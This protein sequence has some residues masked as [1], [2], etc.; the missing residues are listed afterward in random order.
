MLKPALL[1]ENKLIKIIIIT[2]G[3]TNHSYFSSRVASHFNVKHIY[4]VYSDMTDYEYFS[5]QF[6]N[7]KECDKKN[8]IEEISLR[9]KYHEEFLLPEGDE[10]PKVPIT[11]FKKREMINKPE[12]I[13]EIISYK[14]T[15]VLLYGAPILGK[16]ILE[17]IKCPIIN[18]HMGIST[19]YRGGMANY[20]ALFFNDYHNV[21]YTIHHVS[22][23]LDAG[24]I[25]YIGRYNNYTSEDNYPRIN[26]FLLK[27][28]TK[29]LI[30]I[31]PCIDK[32]EEAV[33]RNIP[34]YF[35]ND[36]FTVEYL[37][38]V[39]SDFKSRKHLVV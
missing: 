10:F 38:K 1:L 25:V 35:P 21:G 24:K 19:K 9:K 20:I 28:A 27:D 33:E 17:R 15:H 32:R 23:K 39:Q 34:K 29:N 5:K 36:E 16:K 7:L 18:L 31:I 4:K 37:K 13:N 3:E 8:I 26:V 30:E 2:G 22:D 6:K 11:H 12:T 14:P